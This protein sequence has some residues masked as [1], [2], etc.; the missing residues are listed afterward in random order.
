MCIICGLC[1]GA[2]IAVILIVVLVLVLTKKHKPDDTPIQSQWLNLTNYPPIPTGISTI[3]GPTLAHEETGCVIPATQWSCSLPKEEHDSVAPNRSDQPNF[4]LIIRY[5]NDTATKTRRQDD[6]FSPNPSPPSAEDQAF[7]GN[8]T[9]KNVEPFAGEDT[10]FFISFITPSGTPSISK[11]QSDDGDVVP[12]I[13]DIIPPPATVSG[14]LAAPANLLP[15]PVAQPLHLYNRGTVDEHYGFYTYFDRSIF[16]KDINATRS[17]FGGNPADQDG[18]S[19]FDSATLRCT[20]A[21]TRFL[22]Q[23]WTNSASTKPLLQ[24]ASGTPTSTS[25]A[26]TPSSSSSANDFVTPGSFPYPVT[27]T[28]DRHGGA[29]AKKLVYC[30][31]MDASGKIEPK[32]STITLEDR[33][34]GGVAVN[35]NK[36]PFTNTTVSVGDGGPGGLDGGSGGCGCSW[37]NWAGAGT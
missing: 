29:A 19:S 23:I 31:G 36:G 2:L 3:A 21:Q 27:I 7:L 22:V 33:S 20:W 25:S 17:G 37:V 26:S 32:R 11:R 34:F 9:D 18:G 1:G 16:L 8:T 24:A 10:P 4:R 5:K 30:Y 12:N 14:G 13:E 35:G 15:L 6:L 28:L